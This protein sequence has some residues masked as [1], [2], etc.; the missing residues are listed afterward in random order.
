MK[1]IFS[2]LFAVVAVVACLVFVS[3][4]EK[5]NDF[6]KSKYP[7][8][9]YDNEN[10]GEEYLFFGQNNCTDESLTATLQ[11]YIGS[12]Y[13]TS[14]TYDMYTNAKDW[15]IIPDYSECFDPDRQWVQVWPYE[16]TGDGRFTL[17]LDV[18]VSQGDT[19]Y[20]NVN[21]VSGGKVWKTIRVAQ[22]AAAAT[23][24]D[25]VSFMQTIQFSSDDESVKTIPV[26]ANVA[27]EAE[28]VDEIENDWIHLT[29]KTKSKFEVNVDPNLTGESR[30]GYITIYQLSNG[31]NNLTI[32]VKQAAELDA[33]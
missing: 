8:N 33:E 7:Y 29:N 1:V 28:I 32:T 3:S 23:T 26:N 9:A 16:G 4:C 12:N 18:N 20:A 14:V 31:N 21:I 2:K 15:Q 24:L 30:T 22:D 19:R 13:A 6:D 17:K 5:K 25:V 11:G 10:P 27:W